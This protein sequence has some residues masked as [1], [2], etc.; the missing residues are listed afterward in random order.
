MSEA[1]RKYIKQVDE[2]I[3]RASGESLQKLQEIDKSTQL[4]GHSFYDEYACALKKTPEEK[5]VTKT[6]T[7]DNK[8]YY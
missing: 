8:N 2:E 5:L 7:S 4:N 1:E 6:K 3:L